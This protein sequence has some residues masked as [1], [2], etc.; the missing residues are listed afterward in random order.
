MRRFFSGSLEI[1]NVR[2]SS[3]FGSKSLQIKT[4]FFNPI[5]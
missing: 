5:Y 2:L 4:E 3:K 1:V